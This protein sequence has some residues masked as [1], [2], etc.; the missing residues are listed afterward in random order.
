MELRRQFTANTLVLF[1]KLGCSPDNAFPTQ[2]GLDARRLAMQLLGACDR[3]A[4]TQRPAES[5]HWRTSRC[6]GT[7]NEPEGAQQK[8]LLFLA[9]G[10]GVAGS[11]RRLQRLVLLPAG[12]EALQLCHGFRCALLPLSPRRRRH[13]LCALRLCVPIERHS[14]TGVVFSDTTE[15]KS[16]VLPGT[17]V[18]FQGALLPSR[19][20]A[21]AS[22]AS[23]P[24]A[25]ARTSRHLGAKTTHLRQDALNSIEDTVSFASVC[26]EEESA[27]EHG[28]FNRSLLAPGGCGR[29]DAQ[30]LAATVRMRKRSQ[31]LSMVVSG[32]TGGLGGFGGLEAQLLLL[33]ARVRQMNTTSGDQLCC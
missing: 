31:L 17:L 12:L 9:D 14:S 25:S 4:A 6:E 19:R 7:S 23:A 26:L 24:F 11:G 33:A 8:H 32:L 21:A 20:T 18:C 27:A 30:L 3:P 13:R 29:L 2:Q 22:T 16:C 10:A 15:I 5:E 1:R 28:T